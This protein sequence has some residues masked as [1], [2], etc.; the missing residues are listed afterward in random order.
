MPAN[1]AV[2]SA[3]AA[4]QSLSLS[5]SLNQRTQ[6]IR[7]EPPLRTAADAAKERKENHQKWKQ[8]ALELPG[9]PDR[10]PQTTGDGVATNHFKVTF[11]GT[12]ELHMYEVK[13]GQVGK[14][15]FLTPELR[16]ELMSTLLEVAPKYKGIASNYHS[17][18]VS[19]GTLWDHIST[20]EP[21]P[22]ALR[23]SISC[24]H[25]ISLADKDSSEI[26]S[27]VTYTG[28]VRMDAL[29]QHVTRTQKADF[30][31]DEHLKALNDISWKY[32]HSAKWTGG[33]HGKNFFPNEP[34]L[35]VDL[36]RPQQYRDPKTGITRATRVKVYEARTGF[37][38]SMRAGDGSLILNV[39]PV[40]SAF[41]PTWTLQQLI[42]ARW[43]KSMP[44]QKNL[45]RGELIGLKVAFEG[46]DPLI[47]RVYAV[48]E[49]SGLSVSH[50]KFAKYVKDQE[51]YISVFH[52]MNSSK[53][54]SFLVW[55]IEY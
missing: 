10:V 14:G 28:R 40:T 25:R 44:S 43:G 41:Y 31:I 16:R 29:Q 50:Q 18:I 53:F 6:V 22:G 30:L 39:N 17:K 48:S 24:T 47:G 45:T 12:K 21:D 36:K 8:A 26:R 19:A 52:H 1:P 9:Y 7:G 2:S 33:R 5:N 3:A 51:V 34:S 4:L 15:V 35:R 46:H 23:N 38:S 32:I 54:C 42:Q 13:F 55:L 27:T 49:I 37:H 20:D 11:D